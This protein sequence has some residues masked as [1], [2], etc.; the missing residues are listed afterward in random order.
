MA[1]RSN[2]NKYGA[3]KVSDIF[4]TFDSRTEQEA[5]HTLR[6]RQM[7]GEVWGLRK[8]Q[9][10]FTLCEAII[11]KIPVQLKTKVKYKDHVEEEA[12]RY[13]PDFIYYDNRL[14]RYVCCE[15]KSTETAKARDYR[16]RRALMKRKIIDHNEKGKGLWALREIVFEWDK[17]YKGRRTVKDETFAP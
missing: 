4:G 5:Y 3:K 8:V 11:V 10:Q 15:V 9:K 16:L 1:Y 6:M 12:V 13:K 2:S 14:Q 7:G 17:F